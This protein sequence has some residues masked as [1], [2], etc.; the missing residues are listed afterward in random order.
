[1]GEGRRGFGRK[2]VV[3]VAWIAGAGVLLGSVALV[4]FFATLKLE[5]KGTQVVVPDLAGMSRD[6]AARA[7]AAR[8]LVIEV[9]QQRHDVRIPSG[10]VLQQEPPAGASVRRGRK[11]RLVESL[12]GEVLEVP[13]LV[14]QADRTMTIE[15]QREG[16]VAGDEA[17]VPSR[18]AEGTVLAQ[19]PPAGSPAVPGV[20]V[21]RL[22]SGGPEPPR[23]VM[24]D[25]AGR[26]LQRVERWIDLAGLRK[27]AVRRV[28]APGRPSGTIVGQLPLA[29]YPVTS[30][31][32]VEL[33]VAR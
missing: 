4:S 21:H 14:G 31:G 18:A 27:G 24:P 23:W 6:E 25:L 2:A 26:P 5:L 28:D 9:V 22:V 13:R 16:L 7:A 12:G 15:I 3:T 19:E 20:R 32:V 30:R 10:R 17:I 33:T 11:V 29:G 8:D 1:M